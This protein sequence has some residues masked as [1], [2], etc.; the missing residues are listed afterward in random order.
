MGGLRAKDRKPKKV[1]DFKK[2]KTKVGKKVNRGP[3]T[4]IKVKAKKIV[5]SAQK[6]LQEKS[7]DEIS[8]ITL[9]IRQFHHHSA[10]NRLLALTGVKDLLESSENTESYIALVLPAAME[11]LFDEEGDTRKALLVFVDSLT[12]KYSKTAFESIASVI[13][14]YCCSGLTSLKKD[15]RYDSL[16][17]LLMFLTNGTGSIFIYDIEKLLQH[18][19][20]LLSLQSHS[21]KSG[22]A[23]AASASASNPPRTGGR[24][25][26]DKNKPVESSFLVSTLG[27]LEALIKLASS[28]SNWISKTSHRPMNQSLGAPDSASKGTLLIYPVKKTNSTL[29]TLSNSGTS[30]TNN[31]LTEASGGDPQETALSLKCIVDD[32]CCRLAPIWSGLVHEGSVIS[33]HSFDALCLI[34]RIGV[35]LS[36]MIPALDMVTVEAPP[37]K[38]DFNSFDNFMVTFFSAFPYVL[39]EST[40]AL[41]GSELEMEAK[42][43]AGVLNVTVCE[44]ALLW[45]QQRSSLI[46]NGTGTTSRHVNSKN[47]LN[48]KSAFEMESD[49]LPTTL[50]Y[51]HVSLSF[52]NEVL[53]SE[54]ISSTVS[55][56]NEWDDHLYRLFH[57][58]SLEVSFLSGKASQGSNTELTVT[59][60]DEQA[61]DHILNDLCVLI[62]YAVGALSTQT[63][64]RSNANVVQRLSFILKASVTC[65]SHITSSDNL[66]WETTNNG[67]ISRITLLTK[68]LS[69]LPKRF[70]HKCQKSLSNNISANQSLSDRE[71]IVYSALS[72][73]LLLLRR[74]A[75]SPQNCT[76]CDED[77]IRGV[78]TVSSTDS[79]WVTI[80]AE[81]SRQIADLFSDSEDSFVGNEGFQY[82]IFSN[83]PCPIRMILLDL[84]FYCK[85]ENFEEV[86]EDSVVAVTGS[87]GAITTAER[88]KLIYLLYLRR[89]EL[90]VDTF[91]FSLMRGIETCIAQVND[92]Y[93]QKYSQRDNTRLEPDRMDEEDF[94]WDEDEHNML[95]VAQVIK[96]REWGV[97]EIAETL[98]RCGSSH[99]PHLIVKYVIPFLQDMLDEVVYEGLDLYCNAVGILS[100]VQTL[101]QSFRCA[102]ASS[103]YSSG[104]AVN[105]CCNEA[106][107]DVIH[108]AAGLMVDVIM[109]LLSCH[110]SEKTATTSKLLRMGFRLLRE[111]EPYADSLL[112]PVLDGLVTQWKLGENPNDLQ[113]PCDVFLHLLETIDAQISNYGKDEI[114]SVTENL[115]EIMQYWKLSDNKCF[116]MYKANILESVTRW[117]QMGSVCDCVEAKEQVGDLIQFIKSN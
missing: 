38:V 111:D 49:H 23:G 43:R 66:L 35:V 99:S 92:D 34:S 109:K 53:S 108:A 95:E 1:N 70:V 113:Q 56:A 29:I 105:N 51:V 8:Q 73:L 45:F 68:T 72:T 21:H 39:F 17:L 81:I 54:S 91:V 117:H 69:L 59:C 107:V 22:A 83:Y 28:T 6:S 47:S 114:L 94:N 74:C 48:R 18:V 82:S 110:F 7:G 112:Y 33:K 25:T 79:M 4:V 60:S 37:K 24:K 3:V 64:T 77:E 31:G 57:C 27:V 40:I 86:V 20:S 50:S 15:I 89:G 13:S 85:F 88:D 71:Y 102:S 96:C 58:I 42:Y 76:T 32:I 5:M 52:L 80:L 11:L 78:K 61:I 41:P 104:S 36:E 62:N 100:T 19:A 46:Q 63:Y 10:S 90:G 55:I 116:E 93:L 75:S 84:W 87:G 30:M 98:Y 101:M 2:V 103:S 67:V 44:A 115:F 26:N 16:A 65:A 9:L 97:Y 106:V 14:T 12:R